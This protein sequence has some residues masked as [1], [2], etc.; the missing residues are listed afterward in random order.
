MGCPNGWAPLQWIAVAGLRRYGFA[1]RAA[2]IAERWVTMV[3][4][5]YRA[6]GLLLE[7]YDVERGGAGAGGEYV[8]E[9]GFGWTN[10]VTLELLAHGELSA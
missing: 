8:T 1:D 2:T 9:T 7:K 6:T 10:G 5:H 3:E 4:R